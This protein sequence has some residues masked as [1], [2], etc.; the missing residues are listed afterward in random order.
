M[1]IEGFGIAGY[2]SFGATVQ[3]LGSFRKINLFIGQ[4]NSGK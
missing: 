3:K 4:N 2:T 1:F